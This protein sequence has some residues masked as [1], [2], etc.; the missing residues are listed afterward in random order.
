MN[1]PLRLDPAAAPPLRPQIACT[2][3]AILAAVLTG[4]FG[5]LDLALPSRLVFW[6]VLIGWNSLKW[7]SWYGWTGSRVQ[8]RRGALL[9]A[10]SGALLLNATLPLEIDLMY[11]AIGQ[12]KALPW[13]G[14][15]LSA[16]TIS[17]GIALLVAALSPP[18]I[19]P[20]AKAP[21]AGPGLLASKAGLPDL[22]DLQAVTAEDHYLRL[23]LRDGRR[24]LVLF[25]FGDALAELAQHDGCQVHR[26]AWIAADAVIGARREGRRWLLCLADGT[27]LPVSE[28]H[29]ASVK[30]RGWLSV[31]R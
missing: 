26:S 31:R 14:L 23:H 15:Y 25:R 24:L 13:A 10:A 3:F 8:S 5:T 27:T 17:A 2:L 7:W 30:A 29:L 28:S 22:A 19:V 12:A 20:V 9:V 6:L 11:R 1:S 21:P 4:P 16:L 18:P